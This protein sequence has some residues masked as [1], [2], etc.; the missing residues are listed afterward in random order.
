MVMNQ[1]H[2]MEE[3]QFTGNCLKGSRPLLSFDVAFDNEPHLQVIKELLT[4]IMG[5]PPGARKSKPFVDRVMGFS[6][7][8]GKIWVRNYQISEVEATGAT[9]EDEEVE[10]ET[11]KASKKAASKARGGL[12]DTDIKLIE[13]G[14]RYVEFVSPESFPTH[15]IPIPLWIFVLTANAALSGPR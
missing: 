1:V 7:I 11:K 12:K 14:P 6:L 13:I 4:Q 9:G 10:D 8:D 5:V 2:T 15:L 3:L